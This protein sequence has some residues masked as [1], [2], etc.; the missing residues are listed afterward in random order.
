M[1]PTPCMANAR[2]QK[3]HLVSNVIYNIRSIHFTKFNCISESSDNRSRDNNSDNASSDN[4]N[5]CSLQRLAL[6][7]GNSFIELKTTFPDLN[8][9]KVIDILNSIKDGTYTLSPFIVCS[10]SKEDV[11]P[12]PIVYHKIHIEENPNIYLGTVPTQAD[13]LVLIGLGRMLHILFIKNKVFIDQSFGFR[14]GVKE[15]YGNVCARGVF[16]RLYKLDMT[17]TLRIINRDNLLCKLSYLVKDVYI[18]EFIRKFLY[19]PIQ[20]K[21]GRDFTSEIGYRIPSSALI[22][23]VLLNFILT[24]FDKEFTRLYPGLDYSRYVNEVFVS[25]PLPSK[26]GQYLERYELFEHV[27][28][29]LFERLNL[30]GKIHHIVPGDAPVPCYGGLISVSQDGEIQVIHDF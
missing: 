10:F 30:S 8:L 28:L 6:Y 18:L 11:H 19:L 20:D 5:F 21:S 25:F 2:Q 15:F 26:H 14:T 17:N 3:C 22:T 16:S 29:S 23:D 4:P 13:N 24:E 27:L 7:V 1:I 12:D 9:P